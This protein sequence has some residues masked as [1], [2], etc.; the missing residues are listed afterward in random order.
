MVMPGVMYEHGNARGFVHLEIASSFECNIIHRIMDAIGIVL[1]TAQKIC[2][3][4]VW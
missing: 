1:M 2:F 3:L 4:I